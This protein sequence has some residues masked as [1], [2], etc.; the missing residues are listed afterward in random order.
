MSESFHADG[1]RRP[2]SSRWAFVAVRV[3]LAVVLMVAV[4]GLLAPAVY[5]T[6]VGSLALRLT[7]AWPGGRVVMPLGP[8]GE[9]AL[10]THRTPVDIVM[11]YR[12]P[13]AGAA[14][15][16]DGTV[17]GGLEHGARAAFTR[18]PVTRIPWVLLAGAAAG[19]RPPGPVV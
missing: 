12:L 4:A 17:F 7:P 6:S 18:L 3:A 8:A 10:H 11:D 15:D 9:F 13:S 1:A 5:R 16:G 2:H 19:A 14:M